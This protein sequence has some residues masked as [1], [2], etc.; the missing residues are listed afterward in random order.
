TTLASSVTNSGVWV[1][2]VPAEAGTCFLAASEPAIA[3][4]AI[5]SVKRARNMHTLSITF[6]NGMFAERPP[7]PRPLLLL[8]DVTAY[9]IS[10]KPCAPGLPVVAT[11]AGVIT[12]MAV[13]ITTSAHGISTAR[14]AIFIS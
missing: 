3:S 9:S 12:A 4:M 6:Q 5:A 8:A 13:Q 2:S 7:N 11:A 14:L 1:G 10:L